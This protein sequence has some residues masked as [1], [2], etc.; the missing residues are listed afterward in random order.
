MGGTV[1]MAC[2]TLSKAHAAREAILNSKECMN[3][4]I[5]PCKILILELDLNDFKSVRKFVSAFTELQLPLHALINNAGLMNNDRYTTKDGL[6]VVMT[7]NHL[8]HFLLSN[9]LLSV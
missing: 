5:A 4:K 8:S 7:A 1:I 9:L 3:K 6:E 2:R